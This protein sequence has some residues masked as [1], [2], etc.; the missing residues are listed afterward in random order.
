MW[1]KG[2][3]WKKGAGYLTKY[4]DPQISLTPFNAVLASAV[5]FTATTELDAPVLIAEM[6]P[7][8]ATVKTLEDLRRA[9]YR[10]VGLWGWET[11]DKYDWSG[12]QLERIVCPL[13]P[14]NEKNKCV[15]AGKGND[16]GI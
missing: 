4:I 15:Q 9:G 5:N 16:A 11:G 12:D 13:V 7:Q 6:D 14:V 2:V 1:K 3:T 8:L 10:G